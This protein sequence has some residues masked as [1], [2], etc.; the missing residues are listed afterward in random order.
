M[1]HTVEQHTL[2]SQRN[3]TP[4]IIIALFQENLTHYFEFTWITCECVFV[5]YCMIWFTF[6]AIVWYYVQHI[7]YN[8]YVRSFVCLLIQKYSHSYSVYNCH[9]SLCGYHFQVFRHS[10]FYLIFVVVVV[11]YC[12]RR[13]TSRTDTSVIYNWTGRK[14][15]RERE[16][17]SL[18]SAGKVI[19]QPHHSF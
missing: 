14:N 4:K 9:R 16:R 3:N 2:S 10:Q 11:L 5:T 19:V 12:M 1:F 13:H 18:K 17:S 7:I 15:K 6:W 8:K